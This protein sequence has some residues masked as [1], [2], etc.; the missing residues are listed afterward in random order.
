[1]CRGPSTTSWR[2]VVLE[3]DLDAGDAVFHRSQFLQVIERHEDIVGVVFAHFRLEVIDHHEAIID[4]GEFLAAYGNEHNV[5]AGMTHRFWSL[6]FSVARIF[7][8]AIAGDGVADEHE[9]LFR[10]FH[11]RRFRPAG[12]GGSVA[13]ARNGCGGG[14]AV[15]VPLSSAGF[16]AFQ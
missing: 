15:E 2:L 3:L 5:V 14:M 1:M 4:R 12:V 6:K 7:A 9:R 11:R 10:H 13:P 8:L 16:I